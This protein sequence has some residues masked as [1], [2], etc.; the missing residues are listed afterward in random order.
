[1]QKS[2]DEGWYM[3]QIKKEIN[4]GEAMGL[5]GTPSIYLNGKIMKFKSKEEFFGI[6]EAMLK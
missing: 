4:D 3:N 6:I 1:M 5:E 2:M